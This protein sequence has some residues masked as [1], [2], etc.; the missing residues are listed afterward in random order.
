VSHGHGRVGKSHFLPVV[1]KSSAV[2]ATMDGSVSTSDAIFRP[3]WTQL[4]ARNHVH[5][6]NNSK[7]EAM[8]HPYLFP[9]K[10]IAF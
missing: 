10:Y 6:A 9:G 2:C 4:L 1:H 8:L 5:V 3:P 7:F